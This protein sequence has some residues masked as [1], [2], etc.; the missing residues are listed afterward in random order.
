MTEGKHEDQSEKHWLGNKVYDFFKFVAQIFLPAAGTLYYA[1]GEIWGLPA[2]EQV[3]GSVTAVD[4]FL[5]V[6]LGFSTVSYNKSGAKYDGE[7]IVVDKPDEDRKVFSLELSGD[8]DQL[9]KKREVVFKVN[10]S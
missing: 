4:T 8:P 3:L 10:A 5:G 9:D 1:L 6:M 7:I 2:I